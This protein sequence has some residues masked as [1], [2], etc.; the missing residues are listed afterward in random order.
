MTRAAGK[1][2]DPKTVAGREKEIHFIFVQFL[3][4]TESVSKGSMVQSLVIGN[5]VAMYIKCEYFKG[6][7]GHRKV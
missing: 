7:E 2:W 1:Q 4:K 6:N 3:L 5:L